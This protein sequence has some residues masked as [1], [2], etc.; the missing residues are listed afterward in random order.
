MTGKKYFFFKKRVGGNLWEEEDRADELFFKK[1]CEG[2]V[3]GRGL[4]FL[5]T[6]DFRIV[7]RGQRRDSSCGPFLQV[8]PKGKEISPSFLRGIRGMHAGKG[9]VGRYHTNNVG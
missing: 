7:L 6:R 3:W 8:V 5:G 2:V 1:R 4:S 9:R